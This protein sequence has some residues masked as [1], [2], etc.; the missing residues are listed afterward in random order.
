MLWLVLTLRWMQGI[1]GAAVDHYGNTEDVAVGVARGPWHA[2]G[3]VETYFGHAPFGKP[4]GAAN[5]YVSPGI[6]VGAG[7]GPW[8]L[9]PRVALTLGGWSNADGERRVPAAVSL[10]VRGR[11]GGWVFAL[12][13]VRTAST[14]PNAP[15]PDDRGGLSVAFGVGYAFR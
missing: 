6:E 9:G 5:A 3:L 2:A 13:V 8:R 14:V 10:G 7:W 12:D 1:Q 4:D 11:R 15:A